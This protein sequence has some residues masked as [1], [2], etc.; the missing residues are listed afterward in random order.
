MSTWSERVG[1]AVPR[2]KNEASTGQLLSVA[3][4][5]IAGAIA[6]GTLQA[7]VSALTERVGAGEKRDDKTVDALGD[8][9]GAIIELKSD[10]KSVKTD[11]ERQ[12]QQINEILR[13]LRAQPTSPPIPRQQ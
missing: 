4:V 1:D 7:T 12:G 5:I 2:I 8:M 10:N 6:W 3:V 13:I 11:I 9:K